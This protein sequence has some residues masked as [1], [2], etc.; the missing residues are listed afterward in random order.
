MNYKAIIINLI[1]LT[2]TNLI[3]KYY[4]LKEILN[5]VKKDYFP[6]EMIKEEKK[7][8]VYYVLRMD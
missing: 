6:V 2:S 5:N 3:S 1:A 4:L 7:I 8:N